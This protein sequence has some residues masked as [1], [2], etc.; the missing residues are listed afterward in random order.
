MSEELLIS[1]GVQDQPVRLLNYNTPKGQKYRYKKGVL[2]KIDWETNEQK[3]VF[4]HQPSLENLPSENSSIGF[5]YFSSQGNLLYLCTETEILI[6]DKEQH[7]KVLKVI[8]LNEF[9]DVHHVIPYDDHLF[10][11]STGLDAVFKVDL[12]G[13]IVDEWSTITNHGIWETF[14][15]EKDYRSVNTK[16]HQSH[17]NYM[18]IN[19]QEVWVT[20]FK[21]KDAICLNDHS[22]KIDISLGNPHDG[23]YSEGYL[24]FTTT[25]GNIIMVDSDS[26]KIKKVFN[27]N[28][29]RNL[30][31]PLGWTRGL[32]INGD[33]AY[34]GFT[35]LRETKLRE[36]IKWAKSGF[37]TMVEM[38]TRI[39]KYDLKNEKFIESRN[40]KIDSGSALFSINP[41]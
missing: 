30:K 1:L 39:E 11:V 4:E 25:N 12:N 23:I 38:A 3:V 19:N 16:P 36:N 14:R 8:S 40:I 13:Y 35:K 33:F 32:F 7:Y 37:K 20:R 31:Q 28:E 10:V 2:L 27:L 34:V 41:F 21:Q 15:K 26:Y 22:K 5:K 29:I 9:N 17:P 24:Y 18:F 6:L